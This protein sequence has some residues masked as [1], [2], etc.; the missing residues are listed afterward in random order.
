M[1]MQLPNSNNNRE[2]ETVIAKLKSPVDTDRNPGMFVDCDI[3]AGF[4]CT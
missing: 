4:M 1:T 2:D 3:I